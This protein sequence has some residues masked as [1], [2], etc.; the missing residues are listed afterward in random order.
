MGR[1][2]ILLFDGTWN[3]ERN[4]TNVT[5][6]HEAIVSNG[7][8]DPAQACFYDPGVGTHWYDRL[9]GGA[10]GRGLSE[11]IQKGYQRLIE[12]YQPGDEI[13]VFGFSRGAYTARS[14]VGI[15]RK[16]G[17]LITNDE[18]LIAEA[19][20]LYRKK[21]VAPED[22]EAIEFR[23]RHSQEIR[24]KFIGVWDTVGSLGIPVS[25]VPFNS[26]YYR[27]HD[28]EL[29]K[30]VDFAYH[31][32]AAD[33]NR[34]DFDVA[35]WTKIKPENIEVEQ[36]WFIGSHSNVGGGIKQTPE[37][38]LRHMPLRWI[39]D[40]AEA[41][42]LKLKVKVIVG[43]SDYLSKICDSYAEFMY[44]AYRLVKKRFIR[45]FGGGVKETV[46]P[47][48]WTRY[49]SLEYRPLSLVGHPDTPNLA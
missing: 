15:I 23:A 11:N 18:T 2:L 48:V 28:T 26:D 35:V 6:M 4:R 7:R 17:L 44:G 49:Q 10:F 43:E 12:N 21:D 1:K 16:C 22:P 41:T 37:D 42:G 8:N 24:I 25:H 45:K 5:L 32:I 27:F 14:L 46:D 39:Q 33:E 47:T 3:N 36:R 20:D 30:I 40:K 9:T 38:M 34:K 13:Y 29:S 19:Y 31:A